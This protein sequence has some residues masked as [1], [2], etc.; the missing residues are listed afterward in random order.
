MF[1]KLK[2]YA[3]IPTSQASKALSNIN[4]KT[5]TINVMSSIKQSFIKGY[6]ST[7][8]PRQVNAGDATN[9]AKLLNS[10]CS[11]S[12]VESKL[13]VD[14][15]NGSITTSSNSAEPNTSSTHVPVPQPVSTL[16]EST[17]TSI[18]T[19]I[20]QS[21]T[22]CDLQS[23]KSSSPDPL[24]RPSNNIVNQGTSLYKP[25][26]QSTAPVPTKKVILSADSQKSLCPTVL[27]VV[28][29]VP[30]LSPPDI[31]SAP[32]MNTACPNSGSCVTS[33]TRVS[34]L[35]NR[36]VGHSSVCHKSMSNTQSLDG[37]SHISTSKASIY[38]AS[39]ICPSSNASPV[40]TTSREDP[41]KVCVF[42]RVTDHG[43]HCCKMYSG[44][45]GFS[46]HLHKERRCRNCLRLYHKA[47]TCYDPSFC[48]IRGCSRSDKHSPVICRQRYMNHNPS[49]FSRYIGQNPR[50]QFSQHLHFPRDQFKSPLSEIS[51]RSQYPRH[52]FPQKR[53][54]QKVG[55]QQVSHFHEPR[56]MPEQFSQGTQTL[57]CST[58]SDREVTQRSVSTQ[59]ILTDYS[60]NQRPCE[61][62]DVS[63]YYSPE[64]AS[65]PGFKAYVV[66]PSRQCQSSSTSTDDIDSVSISPDT[67][68]EPSSPPSGSLPDATFTNGSPSVIPSPVT[69]SPTLTCPSVSY[70][71]MTEVISTCITTP[72]TCTVAQPLISSTVKDDL[73]SV[74]PPCES[75]I[76]VSISDGLSLLLNNSAMQSSPCYP[77]AVG[78]AEVVTSMVNSS[79]IQCPLNRP[80]ATSLSEVITSLL[81]SYGIPSPSIP[82][83]TV[84]IGPCL[85]SPSC[86]IPIASTST[87]TPYVYPLKHL[88]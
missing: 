88:V 61:T 80:L 38:F 5:P 17:T 74:S 49:P 70:S 51:H 9:N 86:L 65:V 55:Y 23:N 46:I 58:S 3:E 39:S 47:G 33:P 66:K 19:S 16:L 12:K 56:S 15:C 77:T 67:E 30:P 62:Q 76:M 82:S 59:T 69:S 31:S 60:H 29:C 20:P 78:L 2:Y 87:T 27:P 25:S 79:S 26:V 7:K 6:T 32:V 13:T 72:S 22:T 34:G 11:T 41:K 42:C 24:F 50:P 84:H 37:G 36:S 64:H 45:E 53:N 18:D 1:T 21:V 4:L 83:N 48:E 81:N 57:V 54:F 40:S 68:L 75:D 63:L 43:S 52:D 73:C 71:T 10:G 14:K 44:G 85:P 28:A 8:V 35:L